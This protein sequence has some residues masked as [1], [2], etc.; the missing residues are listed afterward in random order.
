MRPCVS[1]MN[2]WSHFHFGFLISCSSTQVSSKIDQKFTSPPTQ[3]ANRTA[4]EQLKLRRNCSYRELLNRTVT[5]GSDG[6]HQKISLMEHLH[7]FGKRWWY[8]FSSP[9]STSGVRAARWWTSTLMFYQRF[10]HLLVTHAYQVLSSLKAKRHENWMLM[11]RNYF[12][13]Q[14]NFSARI[15]STKNICPKGELPPLAIHRISM[16]KKWTK[17]KTN[18]I[19]FHRANKRGWKFDL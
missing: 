13:S 6:L 18:N 4:N 11:E 14:I 9:H 10:S 3:P 1:I 15:F 16:T 17:H 19:A 2:N 7:V 8:Q 12:R 5:R